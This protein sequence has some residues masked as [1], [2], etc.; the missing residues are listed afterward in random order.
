MRPITL[1]IGAALCVLGVTPVMAQDTLQVPQSI[2]LQHEQIISRLNHFAQS[3]DKDSAAAAQRAAAFLKE[4]YS[5]GEQ[6]V[7]P[8]LGLLPPIAKGEV[9]K[10]MEQ[11]V[12]LADR[13]KSA[14]P[15]FENNH[16]K[17]TSLMNELIAVGRKKKNEELVWL[18]TRVAAQSLNDVEVNQPATILIGDYLRLRLPRAN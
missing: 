15:D 8:P 9:S 4:H 18:A 7:L 6:F 17:I 14:L 13:T 10:D 3:K 5:K 1:A 11:A 16:I 12:A 2:R